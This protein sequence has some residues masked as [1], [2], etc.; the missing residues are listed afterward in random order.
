MEYILP[1]IVILF[2]GISIYTT[3]KF[4][5]RL[6]TLED[7]INILK[8]RLVDT[9]AYF[10]K[11]NQELKRTNKSLAEIISILDDD[12]DDIYDILEEDIEH[13]EEETKPKTK[14][15]TKK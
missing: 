3:Y 4:K 2:T 1:L 14:P 9:T 15:K 8:N 12:I 7:N 6:L 5:E 10:Y 11:Q 13:T